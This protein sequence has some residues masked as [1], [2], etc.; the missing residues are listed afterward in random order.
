[1]KADDSHECVVPA[2]RQLLYWPGDDAPEFA[3]KINARTLRTIVLCVSYTKTGPTFPKALFEQLTFYRHVSGTCDQHALGCGC[4][5]SRVGCAPPE[6]LSRRLLEYFD[7]DK[8]TG[9]FEPNYDLIDP[10]GQSS[11]GFAL[12]ITL[13]LWYKWLLQDLFMV[14]LYFADMFSNIALIS[15][16]YNN[17]TFVEL[18]PTSRW[19]FSVS[20]IFVNLVALCVATRTAI[21]DYESM[22]SLSKGDLVLGAGLHDRSVTLVA[23]VVFTFFGIKKTVRDIVPM[24]HPWKSV[25]PFAAFKC[26]G[27]RAFLVGYPEKFHYLSTDMSGQQ[28][29]L[30]LRIAIKTSVLVFKA[31]MFVYCVLQDHDRLGAWEALATSIFLSSGSLV[32]HWLKGYRLLSNRR[33]LWTRLKRVCM[34]ANPSESE[35]VE[36]GHAKRLMQLHFNREVGEDGKVQKVRISEFKS[37]EIQ[38]H[39]NLCSVCGEVKESTAITPLPPQPRFE[40]VQDLNARLTVALQ[41]N[42]ELLAESDMLKAHCAEL[43]GTLSACRSELEEANRK[44]PGAVANA[45]TQT[46]A[47]PEADQEEVQEVVDAST[48]TDA[49]PEAKCQSQ[50]D[51]PEADF[52]DQEKVQEVVDTST[53]TDAGPEA[54]RHSQ[55]DVQA[56]QR[57]EDRIEELE[58]TVQS[59]RGSLIKQF[60]QHGIKADPPELRSLRPS[61]Q[62]AQASPTLPPTQFQ[63]KSPRVKEE[64]TLQPSF[65]HEQVGHFLRASCALRSAHPSEPNEQVLHSGITRFGAPPR[66]AATSP[67]EYGFVDY[68]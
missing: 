32:L 14:G 62:S 17:E 31:Y 33:K 1:M 9:D 21:W 48:Q 18:L 25:Q 16:L 11:S 5:F 34:R 56:C 3:R 23:L 19:V 50:K 39:S 68:D 65:G 28:V 29:Q 66:S 51:V 35:K 26:N 4:D 42:E 61:P 20:F 41:Q 2:R 13:N 46:Y 55:K 7:Y 30:P 58:A 59:L 57:H 36:Q 38:S 44:L 22:R 49:G 15:E 27:H 40:E 37:R 63:L 12:L 67:G 8:S 47:V 24:L 45:S 10:E 6:N 43:Q 54:T 52:H 60:R 64:H 53:H